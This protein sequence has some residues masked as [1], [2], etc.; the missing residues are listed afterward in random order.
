MIVGKLFIGTGC[1]VIQKQ[2]RL[3]GVGD[4]G[5]NSLVKLAHRQR[6]GTILHKGHINL[7]NNYVTCCSICAGFVAQDFFN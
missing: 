7:G 6:S 3:A 2:N 5:K 1:G 4:L